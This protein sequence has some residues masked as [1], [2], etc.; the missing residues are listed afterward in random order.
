MAMRKFHCRFIDFFLNRIDFSC[1]LVQ[2]LLTHT[3]SFEAKSSF[4]FKLMS[5]QCGVITRS[6]LPETI[7][8]KFS[9]VSRCHPALSVGIC[10][11]A[12]ERIFFASEPGRTNSKELENSRHSR[13]FCLLANTCVRGCLVCST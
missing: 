5:D 9:S 4:H 12:R 11:L 13:N 7:S 8:W 2:L 1:C 10:P 6:Q 3:Q